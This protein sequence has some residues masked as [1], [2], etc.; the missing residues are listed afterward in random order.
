MIFDPFLAQTRFGLGLAPHHAS[1][2]DLE[3][4]LNLALPDEM[5]IR[6]PIAG[7]QTVEP[8]P[9]ALQ[10]ANQARRTEMADDAEKVAYR[11]LL[12]QVSDTKR[13]TFLATLARAVDTPFGLRERLTWFWADHFTVRLF[14]SHQS[15][16]VTSFVE[17]AIRPH[18]AGSFVDMLQA[19]VTHPSIL[20]YLQQVQS[21]GPNSD[22]GKR[23]GRGINENLARELLELHT[24][25]VGGPYTQTDVR[26]LAELLTGLT[27][28]PRRGFFYDPNRAEPEAETV[29]G[30]T[31][32]EKDSLGN[33]LSAVGDLAV[34]PTT[35][36][37][38]AGKLAAHFVSNSP[39]PEMVNAMAEAFDR[40]ESKLLPVYAAMLEH[41]SA[42][43]PK[44]QKVKT[45]FHFV[46]SAL[47]ALGIQGDRVTST[48]LSDFRRY[49][50]RALRIM[51]QP[52]E[53]PLGP[54]G[55]PDSE[56][57]WIIPQFMAGRIEWA[58]RAPQEFL[59]EMPDPREFV[60]QA[61]GANA[62]E[63]VV[64]AAG[65]AET[66]GEG[67]GIVLSSPAFQRS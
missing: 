12:G 45:P 61:L 28:T 65:A 54:D 59:A 24:I 60:F 27:Y 43:D 18:I 57:A 13:A 55:W 53:Q 64:F 21:S 40:G 49:F 36:R 35:S 41:P 37:H 8:R 4:V 3:D 31:Y 47:R 39:D 52:W 42:W 2:A 23:R 33:V 20:I 17:D 29:M 66:R 34:H 38:I 26:Q 48:T 10:Q 16:L 67:V 11:E 58:M 63:A 6:W 32:A 62:P 15:H 46:A 50:R 44:L 51:G 7:L 22:F 56:E 5:A 30:I 19:V 14:G 25:G 1:P 9:F